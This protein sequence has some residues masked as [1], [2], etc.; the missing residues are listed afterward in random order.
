MKAK[1]H[2]LCIFFL[3]VAVTAFAQQPPVLTGQVV[4]AATNEPLIGVSLAVKGTSTGTVTD[5]DGQF[6]LSVVPGA[7]LTVSY[8]GYSTQEITVETQTYLSIQLKEDTKTLDELVV[9][10]YGTQKRSDITGSVTSISKERLSKIPVT[11]VLQAIQGSAAGI[12]VT[13][14]SSIPGQEPGVVIRGR[15]SINANSN[16]YVVVDGIPIS[17][18]GGSLNDINPGD[19]ESIEILKDASA[20]AIYGI[21]GANGVI[22]VT[23]KRGNGKPVIRYNGTFGV[24]NIAHLPEMCSTDE[25]IARYAEGAR[26]NG[27]SLYNNSPV[28]YQYEYDNFQQ[29]ITTDWMDAVAQ[30]GIFS[31]NNINISGST[32]NVKYYVSGNLTDQ[33]GVVQGYNY[34]RYSIRTN[35]DVNVTD[36]LTVGT[37][38]YVVSHNKDGGRANLLQATA[39]TPWAKMYNE[40]GTLTH[41]PMYGETLWANPLLQTTTDPERRQFNI[42]VN[43]YG[44]VNFGKIWKPLEGL[45][46]KLNAGYSYVPRRENT[47]TGASV[48]DSANGTA[49]IYNA[50]TQNYTIENIVSYSRDIEKHH[51]DLT[52]LYSSA[53]RIWQENKADVTGFVN[54]E[55]GWNRLQAGSTHK[56]TSAKDRYSTLS[57]MGRLNYAYDSRY[58]LTATVRRDGSSVFSEGHKYGVFPSVALGWNIHNEAFVENLNWLSNL[59]LRTSYGKSG[60][61]AIGVYQTFTTMSSQQVVFGGNTNIAM[62][63][64]R[65][66]N[67]ELTWETT[68][69]FNIGVDFGLFNNRLAGTV[70]TYISNTYDLLL[71]RQLP[72]IT[73]F[74]N[75][76]ANIGQTE[77]RGVEVTLNSHNIVQKDFRW[78]TGLVF[79]TNKN[80]IVDLYGDGLDDVGNG[81]FIGQPI[82]VI[83]DYQMIGIW[84]ADEIAAGKHIEEGWAAS[85]KAGD[86]KL[87]NL[88]DEDGNAKGIRPAEDKMILGQ[89]TP[90]WTGGLT[91][92]FSYKDFSLSVFL[93]TSQGAMRYNRNIGMA[94]DEL[95]RRNSFAEIGYWTPENKSNEWRSL[96]STS[97]T[98]GYSFPKKAN[99][100][101]IKDVT[102]NYNVPQSIVQ[103]LRIGGLNLYVSGRNLYTFTDWIGFDPEERDEPRGWADYEINYPTV[104]SIVFGINITL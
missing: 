11:N 44:E 93:T 8:I 27:T 72:N 51:F 81:W 102:L 66:G 95:Q 76:W 61:E 98:Y 99:Y 56:T 67:E 60:T 77:N 88:K 55:L 96:S 104:R 22:L 78:S 1:K 97:N 94:A 41:Y 19:I 43:S 74:S 64:D 71:Q 5:S 13:Q 58:L 68:K 34:K 20:V 40:D 54:D 53:E 52:G 2:I 83:Y 28:K 103:K 25:L 10:G 59:K 73:G 29:G 7:I 6:R 69:S 36:Y 37:N 49:S 18:A 14:T 46:Y 89:T 38:S 48:Y 70:E 92:T 15:N 30:T 26:I 57:Q 86:V 45:K 80:K 91:N 24:E 31:D 65:L 4:D 35:L 87:A 84:Q 100:T 39:M 9:V 85:T 79:A 32:D 47:Y 16:P 75:V 82:S 42:S 101:R 3:F 17:K 21:N 23:T 63:T 12:N 33:K 90:K 62:V 50:E